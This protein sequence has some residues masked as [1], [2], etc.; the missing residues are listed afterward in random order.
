M[1]S[2][3]VAKFLSAL[4]LR[5]N[6]PGEKLFQNSRHVVKINENNSQHKPNAKYTI[7]DIRL[8][9]YILIN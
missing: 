9:A 7:L 5:L 3:D 4:A 2:Q 6:V 8:V 1:F